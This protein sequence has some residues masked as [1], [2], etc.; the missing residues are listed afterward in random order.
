MIALLGLLACSD[1]PPPP[2][3][4]SA[5]PL[6]AAPGE[7][8]PLFGMAT[9]P[10]GLRFPL[11]GELV[12]LAIDPRG[13][14]ALV[15]ARSGDQLVWRVWRF[16]GPPE[17]LQAD[18]KLGEAT[19]IVF[20]PFDAGLYATVSVDGVYRLLR[21]RREGDALLEDAVVVES[22]APLDDL[23]APLIRYNDDER[24]FFS[25]EYAPGQRQILSVTRDGERAY[26]VTSPSGAPLGDAAPREPGAPSPKV[27]AA[28]DATPLSIDSASGA[29]LWRDGAGELNL[30]DY[31]AGSW[32]D[33]APLGGHAEWAQFS[34]NG[35]LLLLG[36]GGAISV[37]DPGR[38]EIGRFENNFAGTP[39]FSANG[40]TLVGVTGFGLETVA[41]DHP[42]VATRYLRTVP[43]PRREAL[44]GRGFLP[45]AVDPANEQLYEF[46]QVS[47][48]DR[49]PML[50]SIDAMLEV[51]YA[52]YQAVYAGREPQRP[53]PALVALAEAHKRATAGDCPP[54]ACR[55]RPMGLALLAALGSVHARGLLAAEYARYP[56]LAAVHDSFAADWRGGIPGGAMSGVWLR[57]LQVL[58]TDT[59]VPGSVDPVAWRSR[60]SESALGSWVNM[61]RT[62]RHPVAAAEAAAGAPGSFEPLSLEPPRDVVD[63]VPGAW[64]ELARA[65]DAL[66]AESKKSTGEVQ[67][68]DL[69]TSAAVDARRLGSMAERQLRGEGLSAD[70]YEAL[71]G[72]IH[73]VELPY[74]RLLAAAA[75]GGADGDLAPEPVMKIVDVHEWSEPGAPNG[76]L[77]VA[78]GRPRVATWLVSDRGVLVPATGAFYG[79]YEVITE[80]TRLDDAGWRALEGA[81]SRPDWVN[82]DD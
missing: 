39:V 31:E 78:L 36:E 80:G 11:P 65:L 26:A 56:R 74:R 77:Q 30:L 4:P 3:E 34:P 40:R 52:G 70:E 29:L 76:V 54:P 35:T 15:L 69:L 16:A 58:A 72:Y 55:A 6:P 64:A 17:T 21:L 20:S 12:D 38:G 59:A 79:Y 25:R 9:I 46:Y 13:S 5:A 49:G 66:A 47:T 82:P 41:V 44:G 19:D 48:Q 60:L 75:G 8:W 2:P 37:Q 51:L 45:G 81:A 42:L 24:L 73:T 62:P 33:S 50:L 63:P 71:R 22:T 27:T 14:A 43:P 10:A 53:V 67:I 1:D 7:R 61:R 18:P 23:V 57:L 28:A 68:S 32:G